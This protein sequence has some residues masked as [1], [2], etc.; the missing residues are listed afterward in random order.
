MKKTVVSAA[1]SAVVAAT[2][3][4]NA[5]AIEKAPQTQVTKQEYQTMVQ[6]FDFISK[7]PGLKFVRGEKR[8]K[9]AQILMEAP[10]GQRFELIIVPGSKYVIVGRVFDKNGQSVSL[11]ADMSIVKKGVA[12]K[13]GTG[14]KKVYLVTDPQCPF[15]QRLEQTMAKNP[16]ALK[17]FTIE[18]I[19]MPL[20]FHRNARPMLYYILSGKTDAEKAKRMHEVMVEGKDTWKNAKISEEEKKKIDEMI[21]RGEAAAKELGVRGTPSMYDENGKQINPY[22]VANFHKQPAV[23]IVQ[24]TN[25]SK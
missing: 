9:F 14:P 15:C 18:I 2:L 16:E 20:S 17:E 7:N 21:A 6:N 3:A 5:M 22:S 25:K 23:K 8:D 10:N 12:F 24:D 4:Q 19:P 1:I 13:R 11:P